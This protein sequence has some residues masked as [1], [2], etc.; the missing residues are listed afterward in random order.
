MIMYL[1]YF[2]QFV[3]G[4]V[5]LLIWFGIWIDWLGPFLGFI[6]GGVGITYIGHIIE[7]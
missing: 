1:G 3:V 7:S 2:I 4:L 5:G 6:L